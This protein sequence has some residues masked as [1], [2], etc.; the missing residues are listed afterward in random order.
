MWLGG[1][2]LQE[3]RLLGE[4]WSLRMERLLSEE[5]SLQMQR[6]LRVERL[7]GARTGRSLRTERPQPLSSPAWRC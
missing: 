5:W 7:L 4:E 3:E 1:R 6:P 2:S